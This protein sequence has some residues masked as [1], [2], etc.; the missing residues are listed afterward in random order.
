MAGSSLAKTVGVWARDTNAPSPPGDGTAALGCRVKPGN[1]SL[2]VGAT[3]APCWHRGSS[4]A[5]SFAKIEAQGT[6]RGIRRHAGHTSAARGDARRSEE[7]RVGKE[8]VRT[9]RYRWWT[10]H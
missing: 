9:C 5:I 2:A 4:R 3:A 6:R 10:D 1:D 8:G 7:R